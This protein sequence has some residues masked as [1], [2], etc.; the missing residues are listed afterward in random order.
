MN[1]ASPHVHAIYIIGPPS[2]IAIETNLKILVE[3]ERVTQAEHE[4][5][6]THLGNYVMGIGEIEAFSERFKRELLPN[7]SNMILK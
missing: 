5:M 4:D 1:P 6:E 7:G 2:T 3:R